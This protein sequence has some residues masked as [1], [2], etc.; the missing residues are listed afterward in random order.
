MTRNLADYTDAV[1]AKR[2]VVSM[3][4]DRSVAVLRMIVAFEKSSMPVS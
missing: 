4:R 1:R 2:N 3:K